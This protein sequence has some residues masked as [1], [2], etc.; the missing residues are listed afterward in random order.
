M[1]HHKKKAAEIVSKKHH[2]KRDYLKHIIKNENTRVRKLHQLVSDAINEEKLLT[3]KVFMSGEGAPNTFGER[4]A[5][6]IAAFGGSWRFI[7]IFM[8]VLIGWIILNSL[9]FLRIFDP[10]PFILLN[11]VLSCIAALQAP[12]IMM[13]QNRKEERDRKRAENDYLINLKAEIE[14]RTLHQKMD[15][16]MLE[17]LKTLL[18]IQEEQ[19]DLLTTIQKDR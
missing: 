18:E 1:S 5:D 13:S 14:I 4:L 8:V 17:Q 16:L 19:L 7:I 11:L 6:K 15:L 3:E 9:S 12:V 2:P 10:Y